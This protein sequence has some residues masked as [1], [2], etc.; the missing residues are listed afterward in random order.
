MKFS[1][2][3]IASTAILTTF[4][5]L[6]YQKKTPEPEYAVHLENIAQR[7]NSQNL[8]WRATNSKLSLSLSEA[9]LKNLMGSKL[10][11]GPKLKPYQ[12]D[13]NYQAPEIFDSRE[14]WPQ[15]PSISEIRDQANCGSCWAF[16]AVEAMSDRICIHQNRQIRLSAQDLLQCCE[17]C[18]FGCDGGFP[19]MSW[20]YW[21]T[22]GIVTGDLYQDKGWCKSY[23]LAPCAHHVKSEKYAPCSSWSPYFVCD[24][25]CAADYDTPYLKDK[26]F[27]GESYSVL[28]EQT[29]KEEISKNGPIEATMVVYEDFPLYESG[30]YENVEG[31]ALGGH[32]IKIL[33]YGEENG[34]KYWLVANSWNEEWGDKGFF[35]ILRGANHCEIES[36]G[37]AGLPR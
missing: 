35:K 29:M 28:G 7:I 1:F 11:G 23:E 21:Q 32:A 6:N 19:A 25:N 2:I 30:V 37:V 16:G 8:S 14:K 13:P 15:C 17:E 4:L 12:S 26:S 3:L 36:G 34:K 31:V 20:A 22:S 10:L 33:G 24:T 27:G 5:L 18:G 9:Q